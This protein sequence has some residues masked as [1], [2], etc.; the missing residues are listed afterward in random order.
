M[1]FFISVFVFVISQVV[2][3]DCVEGF[4]LYCC[5]VLFFLFLGIYCEGMYEMIIINLYMNVDWM[6][7]CVGFGVVFLFVDCDKYKLLIMKCCWM[8]EV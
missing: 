7:N 5:Y 1:Y 4:E 6:F 8:E 2:I 3:D